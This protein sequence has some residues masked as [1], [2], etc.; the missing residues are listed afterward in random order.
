MNEA[1]AKNLKD[2]RTALGKIRA[3]R[4]LS[5]EAKARHDT[6]ARALLEGGGAM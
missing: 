2:Y 1:M 3:D 4:D 6:R 5:G